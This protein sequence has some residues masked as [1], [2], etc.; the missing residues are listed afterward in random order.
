LR[1]KKV[2][3]PHLKRSFLQNLKIGDSI[4]TLE[5]SRTIL[6]T[7]KY[8][9]SLIIQITLDNGERIKCTPQHRFL[10]KSNWTNDENNEYNGSGWVSCW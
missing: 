2:S 5:G 6:K 10:V 9:K 3:R 7:V 8:P 4:Q 1:I